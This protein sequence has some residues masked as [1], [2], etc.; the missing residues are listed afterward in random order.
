MSTL[1]IHQTRVLAALELL[2]RIHGIRWWNRDVIGAVV[3][4]GG[5]RPSIQRTTMRSLKRA[6][7][8]QTEQSSWPGAVRQ[9]VRCGCARCEWGLTDEGRRVAESAAIRWT[10]DAMKHVRRAPRWPTDYSTWDEDETWEQHQQVAEE[11]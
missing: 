8:V 6:G 11:Q 10:E 2:E 1:S 9:L 5:Y 7:L 3:G 4:A